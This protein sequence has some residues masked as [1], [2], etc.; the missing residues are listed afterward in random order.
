MP[1]AEPAELVIDAFIDHACPHSALQAAALRAVEGMAT[2]RWRLLPI[3]GRIVELPPSERR[4]HAARFVADWPR[5]AALAASAFGWTM[6]R[7]EWPIDSRPAAAAA[8][9]IRRTHPGAESAVHQALFE[10]RFSHGEDIADPAVITR[11][12][13]GAAGADCLAGLERALDSRSYEAA[14]APDRLEAERL[15]VRAVP[16]IAIRDHLL[17]GAQR[18]AVIRGIIAQARA[19]ALV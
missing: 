17:V 3:A 18:P 19:E 9:H 16:A 13:G 4:M 12:V 15:A 6:T 10:A 5:V 14:L 2:I 7:P 1:K 11:I 8:L